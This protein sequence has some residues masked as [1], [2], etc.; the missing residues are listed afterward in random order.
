[1]MSTAPFSKNGLKS[2]REYRRSPSAIGVDTSSLKDPTLAPAK[3]AQ[4][5]TLRPGL[6]AH[7]DIPLVGAGT[8]EGM[9]MKDGGSG[10]EGLD[11]ELVDE[12]GHV[13][14]TTRSDF[15]GFFLFER[16]TY[17]YYRVRLTEPSAKVA[18]VAREIESAVQV[19]DD[20]P[21]VRLGAHSLVRRTDKIAS[22]DGSTP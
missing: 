18:G 20:E 3:A 10:Y 8:I 13:V 1:M 15:D 6:I 7:V 2:Q 11:L 21:V 17:G 4:V 16:V 14:A 22:A 9:L 19:S 5:V 12:D